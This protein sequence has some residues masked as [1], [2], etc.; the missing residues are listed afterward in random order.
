MNTAF[1][2][3]LCTIAVSV[4]SACG[5]S[6]GPPVTH[7]TL[8]PDSAEQV[9]FNIE[10]TLTDEG[11][12]RAV[13]KSD[14]LLTYDQNTREELRKVTARFYSVAGEQ[15]A[16]LTSLQGG[17]NSRLGTM[18][19]R[20]NV[21]VISKEG[22][23]LNSPHLRYDPSRNE[24][25]SDSAFTLTEGERVTKGV[26]FVSNPDMTNMRILAGAQVTGADVRIPR[27]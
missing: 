22:K 15:E 17:H 21:V 19:A 2:V 18:E 24:I 16:I 6:Q 25:S 1:R 5:D 9:L 4:A 27:R 12:R 23:Q 8:I 11:I 20:G 13:V 7:F 14:T 26:G 10:L 3:A